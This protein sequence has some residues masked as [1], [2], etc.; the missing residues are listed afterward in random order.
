MPE[1][2]G[3]LACPAQPPAYWVAAKRR[4]GMSEPVFGRIWYHNYTPQKRLEAWL[5]ANE[6]EWRRHGLRKP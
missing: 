3:T 4:L 2:I 6:E 5:A 1:I